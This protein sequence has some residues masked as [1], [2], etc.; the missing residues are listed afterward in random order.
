MK[1]SKVKDWLVKIAICSAGYGLFSDNVV[2]PLITAIM[3]DY[4]DASTFLMNY[5]ISGNAI[6]GLISGLITGVLLKYIRKKP[7][8][9]FGTVM[10]VI[11]G[12]AGAFSDNLEFLAWMRTIDS[13]S[14]GIL[15]VT[16]AAMIIEL[17]KS[18]EEQGFVFGLYNTISGIFGCIASVFAG[19]A[20][21]TDWRNAFWINCIGII[22][23]FLCIFFVPD[24][25]PGMA[26]KE[27]LPEEPWE[28]NLRWHPLRFIGAI[29]V[30]NI[31][32]T[33]SYALAILLDVYVAERGIGN[34]VVTG[35]MSI[36]VLVVGSIANLVA[37]SLLARFRKKH[38]FVVLFSI[39]LTASCLIMTI[40][41]SVALL[42]VA[43]SLNVIGQ[44]FFIVYF[45]VYTARSVPRKQRTICLAVMTQ[46]T[47]VDAILCAY[48]PNITAKLAGTQ[49]LAESYGVC[50]IVM[51]VIGLIYLGLTAA[52][53]IPDNAYA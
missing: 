42:A 39:L 11:G 15:T 35:N 21:L 1:A 23:V 5:V 31:V 6:A 52:K 33:I 49:T 26:Q 53:R 22:P 47:Y 17:W 12:I 38:L 13:A 45:D 2:T 37:G 25:A 46:M 36:I 32:Q 19:Y 18:E 28:S 16:T 30:L 9:I 29:L 14:D 43:C 48:V 44:G 3:S 4:P 51:A 20:A 34:S 10:F 24:S 41:R 50:A 27:E 40:C 8:L 7:L